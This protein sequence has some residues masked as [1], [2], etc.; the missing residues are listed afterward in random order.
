MSFFYTKI[1][2]GQTKWWQNERTIFFLKN[3]KGAKNGRSFAQNGQK[4]A[5]PNIQLKNHSISN[6]FSDILDFSFSLGK[7][8]QI[9]YLSTS[10]PFCIGALAKVSYF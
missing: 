8:I 7:I 2:D 5:G 3:G 1:Q 4:A 6:Q 9:N 10:R